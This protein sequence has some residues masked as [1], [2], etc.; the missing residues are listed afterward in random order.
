MGQ[1]Q[2]VLQVGSVRFSLSV[3]PIDHDGE[4]VPGGPERLRGVQADL[5]RVEAAFLAG[6][7]GRPHLDRTFGTRLKNISSAAFGGPDLKTVY[8]GC[9]L[10]DEIVRFG[11]EIAGVKPYHWD[12]TVSAQE[13]FG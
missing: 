7:L 5:A 9:L 3:S 4:L 6:D 10:G 12:W 2:R 8:L 13:V 1:E 11:S